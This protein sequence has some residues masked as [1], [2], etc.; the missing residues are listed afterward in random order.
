MKFVSKLFQV[1]LWCCHGRKASNKYGIEIL[2]DAK[3]PQSKNDMKFRE[4]SKSYNRKMKLN[5]NNIWR[6]C[7]DIIREKC[8]RKYWLL[9]KNETAL[10]ATYDE[11]NETPYSIR[12]I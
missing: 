3:K 11:K 2:K 10:N 8:K 12:L 4:G 1:F 9:T 7:L 6:K 5:F